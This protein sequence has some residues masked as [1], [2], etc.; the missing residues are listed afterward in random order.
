MGYL[1]TSSFLIKFITGIFIKYN[2]DLFV[3]N[4]PIGVNNLF[5]MPIV[6]LVFGLFFIILS[7]AFEIAKNQ[8]EENIELKQENELTI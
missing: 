6:I 1:L 7:K 3:K 8:K 2:D 4:N 5:E